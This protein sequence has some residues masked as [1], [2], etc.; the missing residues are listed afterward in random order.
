[1]VGRSRYNAGG[2]PMV[3][4]PS[5]YAFAAA[6]LLLAAVVARLGRRTLRDALAAVPGGIFLCLQFALL[7]VSLEADQ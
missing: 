6:L 2:F 5:L 3:S 7:D 4:P 1:M